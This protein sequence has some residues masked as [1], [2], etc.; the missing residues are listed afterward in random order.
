MSEITD[1]GRKTALDAYPVRLL[2]GS[3]ER[4]HLIAASMAFGPFEVGDYVT[5][6]VTE[7]SYLATGDQSVVATT[8]DVLLPAGVYDFAVPTG[9]THVALVSSEYLAA[10]AVWKS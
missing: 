2:P 1:E 6:A 7:M 9:V 3:G 4:S 8:S 5:V 10:G